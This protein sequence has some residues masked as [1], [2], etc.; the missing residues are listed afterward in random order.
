MTAPNGGPTTADIKLVGPNTWPDMIPLRS[1]LPRPDISLLPDAMRL[2]IESMAAHHQTPTELPLSMVMGAISTAAMGTFQ[3]KH[4]WT[5]P[6]NIWPLVVALPGEVKSDTEREAFQ[7]IWDWEN[8]VAEDTKIERARIR[9]K[10]K[11]L[12][13]QYNAAL[14]KAGNCA[15]PDER[16]MLTREAADL[17]VELDE[18]P[19]GLKM[20]RVVGDITP[21]KLTVLLEQNAGKMAVISAEPGVLRMMA[22][23]YGDREQGEVYRMAW[24]GRER[25]DSFRISREDRQI[26]HPKLV[27]ALAVQPAAFSMMRNREEMRELGTIGRFIIFYPPS[28]VGFRDTGDCVPELD[29]GAAA[30]YAAMIRRIITTTGE[31]TLTLD[32]TAKAAFDRWH[33]W[34]E[35]ACGPSGEMGDIRDVGTKLHGQTLRVAGVIHVA[36]HQRPEKL[37]IDERTMLAAIEICRK[38]IP[39]ARK[40]MGLLTRRADKTSTA[41][42]VLGRI[43]GPMTVR[44]LFERTKGK[45]AIE[46]TGDLREILEILCAH[47]MVRVT[48]TKLPG[49]TRA[50]DCVVPNPDMLVGKTLATLAIR[51]DRYANADI[52]SGFPTN[53]ENE[54]DDW[55][56]PELGA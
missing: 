53:P 44:D 54:T 34:I 19:H 6:T 49:R 12:E 32:P 25:L 14:K 9:A 41:E 33:A 27:I 52:A 5:E 50:S 37:Q 51:G 23:G 16:E 55:R 47:G 56:G 43:D 11:V 35:R 31:H 38:S 13:T 42:Y 26:P 3:V 8:D 18:M 30:D 45:V 20:R 7:P 29:S 22:G 1:A 2:Q 10:R 39:H 28:N 4:R 40:V 24:S 48:K 17:Q 46:E 15:D 36:A 21:E